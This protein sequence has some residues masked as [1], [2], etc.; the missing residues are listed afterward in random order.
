VQ[1]QSFCFPAVLGNA[2][3]KF[4][5]DIRTFA[6]STSNVGPNVERKMASLVNLKSS[7]SEPTQNQ[8][9]NFGSVVDIVF[10]TEDSL[11]WEL[12]TLANILRSVP[13]SKTDDIDAASEVNIIE[14]QSKTDD[15]DVEC[16][17]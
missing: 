17:K 14:A 8:D 5:T 10:N 2:E 13:E 1:N 9:R 15:Y 7:T 16:L 6:S 4:W 12:A 3:R 11:A